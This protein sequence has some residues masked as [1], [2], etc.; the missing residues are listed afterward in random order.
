MRASIRRAKVST[1][2]QH[3]VEPSTLAVDTGKSLD[4]SLKRKEIHCLNNP[5]FEGTQEAFLPGEDVVPGPREP[6]VRGDD[7]V[8]L[9]GHRHDRAV[10]LLVWAEAVLDG[11]RVGAV[12]GGGSAG[13]D[14][15]GG[16]AQHLGVGGDGGKGQSC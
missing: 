2:H 16:E 4:W 9:A 14:G 6:G 1:S 3:P 13:N 12:V 7:G 15:G 11:A 8:V 5:N 10:V